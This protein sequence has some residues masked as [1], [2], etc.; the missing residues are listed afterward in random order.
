[1]G[2][3]DAS[4]ELR[5]EASPTSAR[6]RSRRPNGRASPSRKTIAGVRR[7]G[8]WRHH[9]VRPLSALAGPGRRA[10]HAAVPPAATPHPRA[11]HAGRSRDGDFARQRPVRLSVRAVEP[12]A[13]G[14]HD[15]ILNPK[16]GPVPERRTCDRGALAQPHWRSRLSH[17]RLLARQ[18]GLHLRCR[19]LDSAS[20]VRTAGRPSRR[21]PDRP[22]REPTASNSWTIC[23]PP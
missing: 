15:A 11:G 18:S 2:A 23:R 20:G 7:T 13:V 21:S 12:A 19:P 1:L 17:R 14:R 6:H 3:I 5:N 16:S 8:V 10:G 22:C 9:S 4:C